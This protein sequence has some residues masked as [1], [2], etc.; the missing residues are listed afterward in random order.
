MY[1]HSG[2]QTGELSNT[3][4]HSMNLFISTLETP[5]LAASVEL[6][7]LDWRRVAR[8]R[9][10]V[11]VT[12]DQRSAELFKQARDRLHHMQNNCD[13]VARSEAAVWKWG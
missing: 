12:R 5:G 4:V 11:S 8:S 9:S 7:Q 10:K 13:G 6:K 1:L 2:M 3:Q